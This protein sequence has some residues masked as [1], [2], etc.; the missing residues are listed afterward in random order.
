MSKIYKAAGGDV[1]Y[2]YTK[3]VGDSTAIFPTV[4]GSSLDIRYKSDIGSA[5]EFEFANSDGSWFVGEWAMLQSPEPMRPMG[6]DRS[7]ELVK[8]LALSGLYKAGVTG[9][10]S[11]FTTGLPVEWYADD[12]DALAQALYG[13]HHAVIN[14]EN[15]R[16]NIQGLT[17]MPQPVGALYG[18]IISKTGKVTDPDGIARG[19]NVVLDIGTGTTDLVMFDKMTYIERAS[20]HTTSSL[21]DIYKA[22]WRAIKARYSVELSPAEIE[23]ALEFGFLTLWGKKTVIP[24][25][26]IQDAITPTA[27]AIVEFINERISRNDSKKLTSFTVCGGGACESRLVN[28]IKR[29]YKGAV[30]PSEP[31]LSNARG[32]RRHALLKAGG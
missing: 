14:G 8:V 23:H 16:W 6:R 5:S 25:D 27:S 20:G 17:V 15:V 19:R 26:I 30:V 24:E 29:S 10:I 11:W 13:E 18:R 22:L 1:G 32:F 21:S 12:R 2:G 4:I 28:I 31:H 7:L 3:V 9:D